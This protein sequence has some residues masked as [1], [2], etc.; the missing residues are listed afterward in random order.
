MERETE[1]KKG[2]GESITHGKRGADCAPDPRRAQGVGSQ[3]KGV[4]PSPPRKIRRLG[5]S[6]G[7]RILLV[8]ATVPA[9]HLSEVTRD[10]FFGDK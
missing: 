9:R 2:T 8:T 1:V 10:G 3:R 5:G 6:L 4:H 7:G